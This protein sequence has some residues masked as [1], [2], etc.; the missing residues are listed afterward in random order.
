MPGDAPAGFPAA[1]AVP[2]AIRSVLVDAAV[3][4]SA[5]AGRVRRALPG[6]PFTVL[7]RPGA[8]ADALANGPEADRT[9]GRSCTSRP[10]AAGFCGPARGQELPLLRLPHRAHRRG[11][12]HGLH[13]LHPEGLPAFDILRA[14]ANTADMFAELGRS[15]AGTGPGASGGH[16]GVRRLPGPRAGHRAHLG[17]APFPA[18]LRQRGRGAQI[19]DCGPVLDGR[20]PP[21]GPGPGGLV[22]ER[23]G[24]RG[25]PG[26][27][28][29]A[30]FGQAQRGP[31]GRPGRFGSACTSTPSCPIPGGRKATPPRWT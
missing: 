15:S 30:A 19:Q 21:A 17:T 27:R 14:F 22:G 31:R 3:A 24:R 20:E 11:L 13:L 4:G 5:M 16:R 1:P 12:P 6:V 28:R 25:R 2:W 10:I 23:P 29:A 9:A 8:L 18:R 26:A 7:E